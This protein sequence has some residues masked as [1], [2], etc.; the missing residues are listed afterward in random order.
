MQ[1]ARLQLT[2]DNHAPEQYMVVDCTGDTPRQSVVGQTAPQTDFC[3]YTIDP[4]LWQVHIVWELHKGSLADVKDGT[5]TLIA[6]ETETTELQEQPVITAAANLPAGAFT[7]LAWADYSPVDT[8]G[9]WFYDTTDMENIRCD[10]EKR[11]LC[12]DNDLRACFGT[13]FEFSV[14]GGCLADGWQFFNTKLTRPQGRYVVLAT[15]YDK[16]R[17]LT[18]MPIGDNSLALTY[19]SYINTGFTVPEQRPNEGTRGVQYKQRPTLTEFDGQTVVRTGDDYSFVNGEVSH[20]TLDMKVTSPDLGQLSAN[21]GI[22]IPLFADRLTVFI[23]NFLTDDSKQ[24]GL[25]VDD[26]FDDET[27]IHY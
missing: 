25:T 1:T 5:S 27:T 4:S 3:A 2:V 22:N 24:G 20:V 19:P 13:A 6:R 9:D 14:S 12:N 23:G 10:I 18:D 7:L 16:Y 17:Q 21:S 11:G 8:D 15:D 26:S